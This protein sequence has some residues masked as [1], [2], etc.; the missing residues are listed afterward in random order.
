[1]INPATINALG[2]YDL[3][4]DGLG[5]SY[6]VGLWDDVGTLLSSAI[7]GTSDPLVSSF[8]WASI[9]PITLGPGNYIVGSG[10]G[11]FTNGDR[12][13]GSFNGGSFTTNELTVVSGR[14][15]ASPGFGFPTNFLAF[16]ALGGNVSFAPTPVPAPL[17]LL[18]VGAAFAYSRTLRKRI[19]T[20]KTPE[21]VSTII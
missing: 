4:G 9:A 3:N 12:V 19:K 6:T 7:V 20:S 5:G 2:S 1:L 21:V 15:T 10:G 14:Q 8:R 11:W 13:W 18:G 16:T 17:P